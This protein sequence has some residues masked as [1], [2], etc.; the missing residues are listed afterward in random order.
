MGVKWGKAVLLSVS[1][2]A[3][4]AFSGLD[5]NAAD[6]YP[7]DLRCE[8]LK[9]PIGMDLS[10]P[11]LYWKVETK[12][13]SKHGLAQ[14]AYQIQV[15]TSKKLLTSGDADLWDSGKIDSNNTI[16]IPYA[17]KPLQYPMNCFWR[18]RVADQTGSWSAWSEPASW[19][20][21]PMGMD[22]WKAKWLG[23][24]EIFEANSDIFVPNMSNPWIRKTY[25]LKNVPESALL[26]VASVGFH[27]VYVNGQKVGDELLVPSVSDLKKMHTRYKTYDITPYLKKGKNAV[28]FWLGVGWAAF[29][30]FNVPERPRT[31]MVMAQADLTFKVGNKL[32]TARWS[33]DKTWKVHSS[34]SY[35]LGNWIW[36]SF[37]GDLYDATKEVGNWGDPNLD[38]SSWKA[39]T[40]YNPAMRV[41]A[42]RI[43]G[44]VITET[45]N[46]VSVEKLP[47]GV[48]KI[49]MG[50]NYNG[51][52]EFALKGAPGQKIKMTWSE[53]PASRL[54]FGMV[55]SYI[56]GQKGEGI[57]KHHFNYNSGRWVYVEGL[58]Y[59]PEIEDIKCHQ[60]AMDM[61]RVGYF[62]CSKD[63]FNQL[64][65]MSL[66]TFKSLALGG[67]IVDCPQRE[68]LGYGGDGNAT[69]NTAVGNYD[70]AAFY[71]KW[72]EDWRDIQEKNGRLL[73]TAP[74]YIGGGGPT[75]SGFII[76]MPWEIYLQYG[77]VRILEECWPNMQKW[78]S[79][80]EANSKDNL[81]VPWGEFWD[82]LGDWL[83]PGTTGGGT[84]EENQCLNDC[85]WV[86]NLR[87]ASKIAGILGHPD[88]EKTYAQRAEEVA[89]AANKKWF[90][91]KTGSWNSGR[92]AYQAMAITSETAVNQDLEKTWTHLENDIKA[93]GHIDAGITGGAFLFKTLKAANR[94]DLIYPIV[95]AEDYPSWWDMIKVH[96]ATTFMESWEGFRAAGHSAL[97]SSYLYVGDWF[98]SG[99]GGIKSYRTPGA[100]GFQKFVINQGY[101][102]GKDLDW[103]KSSYNSLQGNIVSNWQIQGGVMTSEVVVPPNC[104][105]EMTFPVDVQHIKMHGKSLSDFNYIE[106]NSEKTDTVLLKSGRYTF[107]IAL[108]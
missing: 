82:K 79:F 50:R 9:N 62:E 93:R 102:P 64:Y 61:D 51:W 21:G 5:V 104:T 26:H 56:V 71:N 101:V 33:T 29:P 41:T 57:F 75:W 37:G 86:Y 13:T 77:D 3:C 34:P 31:P 108:Q 49:D 23:T 87:L 55:S 92:Q 48:V 16:Q 60:V 96:G 83:P 30:E 24:G 18:V 85:Y 20:M 67:Y 59:L 4:T 47:D 1:L 40:V 80:L 100:N 65:D 25:E 22:D 42:D 66:W 103:V 99:L 7:A 52:L 73:H 43:P 6:I 32:K 44:N 74:T 46:P 84:Q 54:T 91:G 76:A 45:F 8:Y 106:L 98:I 90:D 15:S 12:K 27:E 72:A 95:A 39:A 89:Q 36:H 10:S 35:L 19:V 69:L 105:A 2:A 14:S 38:E 81:I 11:R 28:V 58:D 68:R 94:N 70:L 88:F 78:L 107:T 17:G 63:M 53:N 97:H